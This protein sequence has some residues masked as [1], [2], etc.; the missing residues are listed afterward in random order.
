MTEAS[1]Q[2]H[3]VKSQC[4][5]NEGRRG[6]G[7]AASILDHCPG[8]VGKDLHQGNW[9]IGRDVG[10][11][12]RIGK[13]EKCKTNDLVNHHQLFDRWESQPTSPGRNLDD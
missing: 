10:S 11:I 3:H 4:C 2:N 5:H 12:R 6:E 13:G 7:K 9:V 1:L 8:K